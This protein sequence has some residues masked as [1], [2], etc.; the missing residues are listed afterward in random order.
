[1]VRNVRRLAS[2]V[3]RGLLRGYARLFH[4]IVVSGLEHYPPPG[5]NAVVVPN[6]LSF[7]DG[8]LLAAFLPG[9]PVFAVDTGI[10]A[11]WWARPIL[12]L[13]DVFRLDPLNPFAVRT[14]IRDVKGG[15]R[16]VLFP[17]GR[18]SET[19]ALMKVYDGAGMIAD[20]T[21]AKLVPVR[22]EGTQYSHL[23]R[24]SGKLRRRWFPRV[25]ITVLPPV[26][27]SLDPALLGRRRRQAA[28][29]ALQDIMTDA[30]FST[31]SLD[32]TLFAALLD[33]GH[34]YGWRTRVLR[35]AER[36]PIVYRRALGE[37]CVLGRAL[38]RQTAPGEHVGVLLPNAVAAVVTFLALQA[39]SRVPAV[40]NVTAGAE[41]MLTAC[42]TARI[43]IVVSSRRFAERGRLQAEIARMEGQVVF[44]WLEDLRDSFGLWARMQGVLDTWLAHRL[45]GCGGHADDPAVVL[46]TSGTEGVPKGVVL[47]HRNI[48]ANCAQAAAVI[49]FTSADLVFNA[50]PMFHAF[51]LTVATLLPLLSGVPVFLYPTPLHYRLVPELIYG[52]DATIVFSTDTFLTG[53]ARYAHPYDFRSVRYLLTGAEP[54]KEATRRLY[55]DRFGVRLLE[56][57]GATE[58]GPVLSINTPMRGAAGSVGR[59]LPGLSW[60]LEQVEGLTSAG[61]LWVSGPNV[62]LGYLRSSAPGILEPVPKG[63]YDT[64]D[65]VSLDAFGFIWVKDRAKRFAKIGGEMVPMAVGEHLAGHIWPGDVHAVVAV[66]DARKG[67]RLV[68]VT[69]CMS[70][71]LD[72]L[73]QAANSQGVPGIMVPRRILKLPRLPRLGSGKINYPAVQLLVED[74]LRG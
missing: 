8:P 22:I 35:D 47:S 71:V 36:Q 50:L 58:T 6:H 28:A 11:R 20:K 14:L 46:F 16:L 43:R 37:A 33:A 63:W 73:L 30:A 54:L 32:R 69:S 62:M 10:A 26:T 4:G 59:F 3:L 38:A 65:I 53:W 51:G 13:V 19:G 2:S 23:S 48:L 70:A 60:R 45:P 27:L 5:E 72:T 31:R 1:V 39:F 56:G 15:R 67:A 7:A 41:G 34:R 74:S 52:S 25:R 17:E 68:L 18:I 61:R 12:A 49:D 55:A 24:L 9:D 44:I 66:A 21:A 29:Q 40:L 57:Y 64:G 42:R